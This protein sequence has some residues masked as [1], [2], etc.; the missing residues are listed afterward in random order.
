[1]KGWIAWEIPESERA[2]LLGVFETAYPDVIAHHITHAFGVSDATPLPSE[3]ECFIFGIADDGVGVQAL[4]VDMG[5]VRPDGGIHHVTWSID[6][7]AGR[8]PK[9]SND[10]IR[11]NGFE[12]VY[13][14]RVRGLTAKFYPFGRS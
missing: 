13:P 8:S 11:D 7:A 3:T 2:R 1:M 14:V 9:Q 12:R 6:R 10:V 5:H 4:V